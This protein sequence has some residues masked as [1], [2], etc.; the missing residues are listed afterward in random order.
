MR[1]GVD[2]I[3]HFLYIDGL[4]WSVIA[5]STIFWRYYMDY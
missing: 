5:K 4:E 1:N 2:S 3:V